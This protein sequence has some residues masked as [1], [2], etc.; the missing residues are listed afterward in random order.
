[1]TKTTLSRANTQESDEKLKSQSQLS[2]KKAG[3]LKTIAKE[4]A[5]S[6]GVDNPPGSKSTTDR[7]LITASIVHM[8]MPEAQL[9]LATKLFTKGT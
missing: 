9:R 6:P 3:E 8:R 7:Q 2:L 1:M 4:T 5:R